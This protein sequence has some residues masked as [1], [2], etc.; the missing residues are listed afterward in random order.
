MVGAD[1]SG[2]EAVMLAHY[3]HPYDGGEFAKKVAA[4]DVHT[5]NKNAITEAGF[6]ISRND[7]K[8]CLYAYLYSAGDMKLGTTL[9]SG[10]PD[11]Q[12]YYADRRDWY[13][14][15][16]SR[17]TAKVWSDALKE[18]RQA[19]AEEAALID[20]GGKVRSALERGIAGMVDL[21][22]ALKEASKR[23]YLNVLDRRVPVRNP[24]AALNTLL[25]SSAAL[26]NKQWVVLT[27]FRCRE[28]GVVYRPLMTIHDEYDAEMLPEYVEAYSKICLTSV[29]DA[30]DYY[31]IR[32]PVTGELKRGA[33]W[34]SIH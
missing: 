9:V 5:A 30:G 28:Q 8:T 18:R 15:N 19:T 11:A 7:C 4:G 16:P 32:L 10:T 26:I 1:L 22:N 31:R 12:V 34:L 13:R 24:R 17:I 14:R 21:S 3:L 25:Q 33:S 27:D 29:R 23:K 2:I 20:I 6:A